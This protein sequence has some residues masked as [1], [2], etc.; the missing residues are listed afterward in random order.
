MFRCYNMED[1]FVI[2]NSN[3]QGEKSEMTRIGDMKIGT[4][5]YLLIGFVSILLIA[6]GVFGL[7]GISMT[8][9]SLNTVYKNSVVPL[10]E[11][12]I[13]SDMYAVNIVDN[14]HKVRNGNLSWSEG[15]QNI[16]AAVQEINKQWKAYNETYLVEEEKKLVDEAKPLMS[17]ANQSIEKLESIMQQ[18]NHDELTKY[19][20]NELYPV[21]DPITS[22]ISSL[23]DLQIHVAKLEYEKAEKR[24]QTMLNVSIASIVLGILLAF[25]VSYLIIRSVT[26]PVKV[27]RQE[28]H[29]LAERGGDLTQKIKINSRDEIGQLAETVNRFL[30][31]LKTIMIDVNKGTHDLSETAQQLKASSQQVTTGANETAITMNEMSTTVE[32]VSSNIQE[33]SKT[34]MHVTDQANEGQRG[35]NRVVRQIQTIVQST[36]EVSLAID[37]LSEKSKEINQIVELITGVAEQTN[38]L[39]LNAAIEAARAGEQGRGFAVVAEEVRKLAEQSAGASNQI[40]NLITAIQSESQRAVESMAEGGKDVE[41]GARVVQEV[42]DLLNRIIASVQGLS[43][44]IQAVASATEQMSSGVQS[45]AAST[46]EQTATIEEVSASADSLAQLAEDLSRLIGKFKV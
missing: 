45:V 24:Y 12:K 2:E 13:V 3:F 44:Q 39:A 17:K 35:L 46:E 33:I 25:I 22:K 36:R 20:I 18:E 42:G 30:A 10:Q 27:L 15:R 32:Q 7:R 16:E 9:A 4:R 41:E 8:N 11:L 29:A 26:N 23:I 6:I 40:K 38:L 28:L 19:T 21:I 5:L 1:F 37:G 43:S 14:A 31:N 34:S